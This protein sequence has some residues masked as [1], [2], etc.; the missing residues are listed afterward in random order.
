MAQTFIRRL[1]WLFVVGSFLTHFFSFAAPQT[2]SPSAPVPAPGELIDVG[3][4]RLHLYCTGET[5]SSQPTVILEAGTGDFSVEWALVQPKL[6]AFLRVCSY[7]RAGTGWSELGPHP[8]TMHQI[9]YELHVLLEKAGVRPPY[10]LVGTRMVGGLCVST[11]R[12][13]ARTLPA[14]SLSKE[15]ST[16]RGG[17]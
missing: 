13:T 15:G 12:N 9:N 10:V 1:S 8:R 14:W 6:A 3:G 5:K 16:T 17:W 11:L 7:D 4:W 2:E